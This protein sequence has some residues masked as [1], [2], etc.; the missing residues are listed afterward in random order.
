PDIRRD[1]VVE[2]R[3]AVEAARLRAR[4]LRRIGEQRQMIEVAAQQLADRIGLPPPHIVGRVVAD[5]TGGAVA[6]G[7]RRQENRAERLEDRSRRAV[8]A[9]E[10]Q[11]AVPAA[12][13]YGR[14]PA[15]APTDRCGTMGSTR[16]RSG[17]GGPR[18]DRESGAARRRRRRPLTSRRA[19]RRRPWPPT[20]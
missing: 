1:V 8:G 16:T 11:Q 19:A 5:G 4:H 2:E 20:A 6:I 7:A 13:D 14:T 17:G 3:D 12:A 9:L 18:S 10:Q 15:S